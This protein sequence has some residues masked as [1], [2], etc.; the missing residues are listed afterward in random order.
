MQ[1]I[2]NNYVDA[3]FVPTWRNRYMRY[4][5]GH[6]KHRY[7]LENRKRYIAKL[8]LWDQYILANIKPGKTIAWDVS[9]YYLQDFI[10]DLVVVEKSPIVLDWAPK[11]VMDFDENQMIPLFGS[12]DNLII[13]NIN[14]LRW[15]DI[16]YWTLWWCRRAVY[17]RP[18]AQIFF[19]FRENRLLRN[20]LKEKFSDIM[21]T[22]LVTMAQHG[23]TV[24]H[25]EYQP[26]PIDANVTDHRS[27]P[28]ISDTVN[29][30]LKIHWEYNLG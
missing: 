29:G 3:T 10:K 18:G 4:R 17:L 30:N 28:E 12:A 9:G 6:P 22:W 8:D 13:I 19:S 26:C 20:R 23:F 14:E 1:K 21:D 16:D 2:I 5:A 27:A 24:K 7:Y 15:K 11:C 25:Y